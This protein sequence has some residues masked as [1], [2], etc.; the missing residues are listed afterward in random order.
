MANERGSFAGDVLPSRRDHPREELLTLMAR[1]Y[2]SVNRVI[3]SE[4][5][6]RPREAHWDK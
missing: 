1:V 6:A 3:S 4:R 5:L 2:E